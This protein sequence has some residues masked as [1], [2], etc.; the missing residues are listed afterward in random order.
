MY[1]LSESG[2]VWEVNHSVKSF[3]TLY[4]LVYNVSMAKPQTMLIKALKICGGSNATLASRLGVSR[5]LVYAWVK[6]GDA[7]DWRQ[8]ALL[9]IVIR[10]G[11]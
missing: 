10:N 1:C 2:G 8:S 9:D 7:P 5:Q 3:A 11:R 6:K 4:R